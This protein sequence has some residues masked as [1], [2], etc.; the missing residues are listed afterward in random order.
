MSAGGRGRCRELVLGAECASSGLA[1]IGGL[2]ACKRSIDDTDKL[3]GWR[4][5]AVKAPCSRPD[6]R[7]WRRGPSFQ[8]TVHRIITPAESELARSSCS[9]DC[10]TSPETRHLAPALPRDPRASITMQEL[11]RSGRR[12]AQVRVGCPASGDRRA[13][14]PASAAC[15][16]PPLATPMT[17]RAPPD[18]C[19][20]RPAARRHVAQHAAHHPLAPRL[21][22][23]PG[24]ARGR[25]RRARGGAAG[26]A[27]ALGA[28][29]AGVRPSWDGAAG[30]GDMTGWMGSN[31]ALPGVISRT[32]L[33][34]LH[35]NHPLTHPPPT[36]PAGPGWAALAAW[37]RG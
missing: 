16:L 17:S 31:G 37:S 14:T 20:A 32:M 7:A 27:L 33:Q 2:P 35:P 3:L 21:P 25:R 13:G 5:A 26:G 19:P 22:A 8:T 1:A 11:A 23:P 6:I 34:P 4:G 30:W 28:H 9:K 12:H 36:H 10:K 15:R 29:R 24:Q 18:S